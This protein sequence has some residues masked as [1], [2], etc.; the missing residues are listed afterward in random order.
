MRFRCPNSL[1]KF[2]SLPQAK[3]NMIIGVIGAVIEIA[4]RRD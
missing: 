1:V 4:E 2:F 3:Q